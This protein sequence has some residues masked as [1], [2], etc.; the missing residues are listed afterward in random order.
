MGVFDRTHLSDQ[1]PSA[2]RRGPSSGLHS[3][4]PMESTSFCSSRPQGGPL[5]APP[6]LTR[7]PRYFTF[8]S[9]KKIFALFNPDC[10]LQSGFDKAG[11]KSG[12]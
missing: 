12:F 1:N 6:R 9:P 4:A 7:K 10:A 3:N 2:P 5:A 8:L 11:I